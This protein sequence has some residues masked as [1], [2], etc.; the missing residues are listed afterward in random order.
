[1]NFDFILLASVFFSNSASASSFLF[2]VFSDYEDA[3]EVSGNW[4][5]RYQT[6]LNLPD[7]T[8]EEVAF[9]Y[10]SLVKVNDDFVET[11][12]QLGKLVCV[13]FCLDLSLSVSVVCRFLLDLVFSS[14][15]FPCV[16]SC[17]CRRST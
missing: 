16:S 9:K 3:K 17:P 11:A 12:K 6:V 14:L 5:A 15:F 2:P 4:N 10:E 7:E 13:C 1:L 8:E